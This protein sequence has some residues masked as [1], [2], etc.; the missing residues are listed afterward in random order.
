MNFV[1]TLMGAALGL[2]PASGVASKEIESIK[3]AEIR[4]ISALK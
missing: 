2:G 4:P 1:K 3:A